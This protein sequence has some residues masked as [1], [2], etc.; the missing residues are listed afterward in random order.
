MMMMMISLVVLPWQVKLLVPA[1]TSLD[2]KSLAKSP[3]GQH[4]QRLW[5]RFITN[6]TFTHEGQSLLMA[7]T[8]TSDDG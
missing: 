3:R 7:T 2:P 4:L 6:L 1:F 5:L 8:G